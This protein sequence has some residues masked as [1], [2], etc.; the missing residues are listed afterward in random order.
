M[1]F[2]DIFTHI[3]GRTCVFTGCF[4]CCCRPPIFREP[5]IF[6]GADVTHPPA[7]D[8]SKPSISA[9][10][11]ILVFFFFVRLNFRPAIFH[12]PVIFIGADVTHPPAGDHSKPSIAAVSLCS[13]SFTCKMGV[14]VR[15]SSVRKLFVHRGRSIY[16]R[17]VVET[18]RV[19]D[20][21]AMVNGGSVYSDAMNAWL[22]AM[23]N[24][25]SVIHGPSLDKLSFT[26]E[27]QKGD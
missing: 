22:W 5:V 3:R 17:P 4:H 27:E 19:Y 14:R 20:V 9:V 8:H 2:D 23:L 12:E 25:Q 1:A 16:D 24:F 13:V 26:T 10:S 7:G 18:L 6:I 21:I 11:F 15:T